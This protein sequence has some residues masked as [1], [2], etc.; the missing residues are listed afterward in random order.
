MKKNIFTRIIAIVLV[1][2][3]IM[4]IATTAMATVPVP[5]GTM[6]WVTGGILKMRSSAQ[7]GNNV[8]DRIPN[9]MPVIVT[10]AGS[11]WSTIFYNGRTGY[12]M[13]QYLTTTTPTYSTPQNENMAF[14]LSVLQVTNTSVKNHFVYNIQKC[15]IA[16]GFLSGS[17]DG[18]YGNATANAVIAFQQEINS[19]LPA[20]EQIAVDGKVGNDTRYYLWQK[21]NTYMQNYGVL[22]LSS[23]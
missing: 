18:F 7:T 11:T 3:S 22:M 16:G 9:G 15:L 21:Y 8:I 10:N 12:V 5:S 23:Y 20:N 14:G 17:P 1:A 13:S 2:M 19:E 6:K 4:A